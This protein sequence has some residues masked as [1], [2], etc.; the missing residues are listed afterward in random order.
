VINDVLDFSKI[1]AGQLVLETTNFQLQALLDNVMSLMGAA[2]QAKGLRLGLEVASEPLWLQGDETRLRQ[3]LINYV[4]NAIKFTPA[5]SIAIRV[6][7]T[8]ADE[9]MLWLRLEV[10]DS[11]IGVAP[12]AQGR[13]FSAF[14]QANATSNREQGGTGLGLAITRRLAVLMGGDAGFESTPGQGSVFWLTARVHPGQALRTE[15]AEPGGDTSLSRLRA[16]PTPARV[17]VVDDDPFNRE[18]ACDFLED[19]GLQVQL[20]KDGEQAVTMAQTG[21]FDLVLMDVQMPGMDGLTACRAIR[22]LPGWADRPILALTANA[23][24][25][26]RLA[27]LAAGMKDFV[28]KPIEPERL[29]A[30]ILQW[31][32]AV[33]GRNNES[34]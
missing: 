21:T 5:G 9:G 24:E 29:Y 20:A 3:A 16:R 28:P 30:A 17:L 6:A 25:Q 4:A 14:E 26:D 8:P 33:K 18:I 23:F 2:A 11:G 13:I 32:D 7:V 27:C 12:E 19:A 31:L 1:E 22:A 10:Q 34:V 15:P